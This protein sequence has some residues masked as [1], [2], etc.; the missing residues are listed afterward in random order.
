MRRVFAMSIILVMSCGLLACGEDNGGDNGG[1]NPGDVIDAAYGVDNEFGD[2]FCG[3]YWEAGGY[4]S[5]QEC[6]DETTWTSEER[7]EAV[8]CSQDAEAKV[9]A[10]R[11]AEVGEYYSC[12]TGAFARNKSCISNINQCD[13]AAEGEIDGCFSDRESEV[14]AC[15]EEVTD[16][17]DTEKWF[18]E[19][20]DHYQGACAVG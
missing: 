6:L 8:Q 5:E 20:D 10:E 2:W 12:V 3:C 1:D 19:F 15:K 7:S 17:D 18:E 16:D 9:E 11:T 14:S 4:S 13:T